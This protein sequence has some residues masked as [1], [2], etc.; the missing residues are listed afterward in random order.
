M[1]F[2]SSL[3]ICNTLNDPR[4]TYWHLT[5]VCVCPDHARHNLNESVQ[6]KLEA[7]KYLI[8]ANCELETE[9]TGEN[10]EIVG[11]GVGGEQSGGSE[12][13]TCEYRLELETNLCE[14]YAKFYKHGEGHKEVS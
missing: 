6:F 14:D 8:E 7:W 9:R 2:V 5:Q 12:V 4:S 1:V 10:Q 11:L 13:M 3:I